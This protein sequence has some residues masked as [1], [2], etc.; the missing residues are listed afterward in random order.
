[1]GTRGELH[2][3]SARARLLH[4]FQANPGSTIKDGV[5]A[6]RL[7]TDQ[8][9][10][11]AATFL[12]E[13]EFIERTNSTDQVPARYAPKPESAQPVR[14]PLRSLVTIRSAEGGCEEKP[15]G[16]YSVPIPT[17]T[18][19]LA[20]Y[21]TIEVLKFDGPRPQPYRGPGGGDGETP[22]ARAARDS[23]SHGWRGS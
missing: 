18:G 4:F 23:R 11:N 16:Q 20:H 9:G 2:A 19:T 15:G 12:L 6:L 14:D 5:R 22:A 7:A 1:M 8:Q 21:A 13:R 3:G 17:G 10:Y